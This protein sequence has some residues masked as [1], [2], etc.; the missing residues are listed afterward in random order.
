MIPIEELRKY[1]IFADLNPAELKSLSGMAETTHAQEGEVFIRAGLPAH[2]LY[3]LQ[4]GGHSG[5]SDF[6]KA[7]KR[8]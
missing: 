5:W 7:D 1:E 4:H 8:I 2:T 6:C 3:I